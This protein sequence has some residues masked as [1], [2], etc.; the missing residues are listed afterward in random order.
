MTPNIEEISQETQNEEFPKNIEVI[1]G[2]LDHCAYA[3]IYER[4]PDFLNGRPVYVQTNI[5]NFETDV[6]IYYKTKSKRDRNDSPRYIQWLPTGEEGRFHWVFGPILGERKAVFCSFCQVRSPTEASVWRIYNAA[7]SCWIQ[8]EKSRMKHFLIFNYDFPKYVRLDVGNE[9]RMHLDKQGR[10]LLQPNRINGRVYYEQIT[11]EKEKGEVILNEDYNNKQKER[12]RRDFKDKIHHHGMKKEDARESL[13]NEL[14]NEKKPPPDDKQPPPKPMIKYRNIIQ[15]V[16][17]NDASGRK[18]WMIGTRE[19][20]K[21]FG[22]N[23]GGLYSPDQVSNPGDCKNW[24]Y[25]TDDKDGNGKSKCWKKADDLKITKIVTPEH[26]RVCSPEKTPA[27][28]IYILHD[29]IQNGHIVYKQLE[30]VGTEPY[31]IQWLKNKMGHYEW[32]IGKGID[33]WNGETW[34]IGSFT[35]TGKNPERPIYKTT[36]I[37]TWP[38]KLKNWKYYNL[39]K[40]GGMWIPADKEFHIDEA[41]LPEQI[42]IEGT[43]ILSGMPQIGTYIKSKDFLNGRYYWTMKGSERP[44][45]IQWVQDQVGMYLWCIGS[46]KNRAAAA[47]FSYDESWTP[48]DIVNWKYFVNDKWHST[49]ARREI[50]LERNPSMLERNPINGK[51]RNTVEI[52]KRRFET[53]HTIIKKETGPELVVIYDFDERHLA[54]ILANKADES[55]KEKLNL[56]DHLCENTF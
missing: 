31:Y 35:L 17:S 18:I 24:F 42:R 14:I 4:E 52:G 15:W 26:V 25:C 32:I 53:N 22:G 16:T 33:K 6:G 41:Y 43:G 50:Q 48:Q 2:K 47:I 11:V 45:Y 40:R 19:V 55:L 54:G 56:V 38:S 37:N 28:G 46:Q 3:G 51:Q 27:D 20:S 49:Q 9:T 30:N 23:Y 39:N 36:N 10:Y 12:V 44:F 8:I 5:V 1:I 34:A 13:R 7:K 29:T 21:T